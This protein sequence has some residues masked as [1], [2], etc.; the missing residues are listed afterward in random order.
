MHVISKTRLRRALIPLAALAVAAAFVPTAGAAGC[1]VGQNASCQNQDMRHLG[2]AM[3]GADMS[4]SDM[5]GA[6]LRGMNLTNINLSGADMRGAKL[7]GAKLNG[8]N[9]TGANMA[10]MKMRHMKM[11]GANFSKAT[12]HGM[13]LVD[14]TFTNSTFDGTDMRGSHFIGGGMPG[15]TVVNAKLG[16]MPKAGAKSTRGTAGCDPAYATIFSGSGIGWAWENDYNFA[17]TIWD[18]VDAVCDT[19]NAVTWS[20]MTIKNSRLDAT[21]YTNAQNLS[22]QIY[23]ENTNFS[24]AH[25]NNTFWAPALAYGVTLDGAVCDPIAS[26]AQNA[27]WGHYNEVS[28]YWVGP[29]KGGQ[30]TYGIVTSTAFG[31]I[32]FQSV[33]APVGQPAVQASQAAGVASRVSKPYVH[34]NNVLYDYG[35]SAVTRTGCA[36][37]E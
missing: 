26:D 19:F 3:M 34:A 5:R 16:S 13:R 15:S 31:D 20:H 14:V 9:M 11:T 27:V 29:T 33:P 1:T 28:P 10:G 36:F 21:T 24:Q 37:S 30:F 25:F 17:S 35:T 18:G 2:K 32:Q 8:A 22:Q 7:S 4:G 12:M 23:V 6:D